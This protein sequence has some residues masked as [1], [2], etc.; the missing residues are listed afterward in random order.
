MSSLRPAL[1]K[2]QVSAV[3]RKHPTARVV[4]LRSRSR[5]DGSPQLHI[6]DEDFAVAQCASELAVRE[7]RAA[8]RR[9]PEEVRAHLLLGDALLGAGQ[10]AG[11]RKAYLEALAV[12][13]G[14]RTVQA[15]L[16]G[17]SSP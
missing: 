14:H 9:D 5:W 6:G 8:I 3:R 12:A 11:A 10:V 16:A 4:A 1:L 7:A 15:R 2:S 17:L 13:P